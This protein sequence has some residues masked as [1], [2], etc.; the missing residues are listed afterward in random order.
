MPNVKVIRSLLPGHQTFSSLLFHRANKQ[1]S[2]SSTRNITHKIPQS[3][4]CLSFCSVN[5]ERFTFL[6]IVQPRL[7]PSS[8]PK[9]PLP[10]I[11]IATSFHNHGRRQPPHQFSRAFTAHFTRR[12]TQFHRI[13]FSNNGE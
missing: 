8:S 7:F 11:S 2:L 1:P 13:Q 6:P 4:R 9:F 5:C 3:Q 12:A 10:W